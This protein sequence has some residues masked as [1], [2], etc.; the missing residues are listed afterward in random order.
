MKR[1]TLLLALASTFLALAPTAPLLAQPAPAS[2]PMTAANAP[3]EV[4]AKAARL[5]K[6]YFAETVAREVGMREFRTNFLKEVQAAP[7]VPALDAA[8]PGLIDAGLKAGMAQMNAFYDEMIPRLNAQ[9][10]GFFVANFT[11]EQMDGAITFYDS[12]AGRKIMRTAING[13]D[14]AG[15][16]EK[17]KTENRAEITT[18]DLVAL[19]GPGIADVLASDEGQAFAAFLQSPVGKRFEVIAPKLMAML[20][21]A[22]SAEMQ[23]MAPGMQQAIKDAFEAHIAR[24]PARKAD[25]KR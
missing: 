2:V 24:T 12:P 16:L 19:T 3:P 11:P 5:A 21:S 4:M 7:G 1:F 23:R 13:S 8:H 17:I 14:R 15:L 10:S 20:S 22:M 6:L 18:N 9:V 25:A